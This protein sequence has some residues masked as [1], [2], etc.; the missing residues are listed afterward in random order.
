[1]YPLYKSITNAYFKMISYD[2]HYRNVGVKLWTCF[3]LSASKLHISV[4]FPTVFKVRRKTFR[5]L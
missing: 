2:I 1:M 4:L 3:K 5:K